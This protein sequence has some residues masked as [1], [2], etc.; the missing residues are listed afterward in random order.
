[1]DHKSSRGLYYCNYYS[2]DLI[3]IFSDSV[4]PNMISL[5]RNTD[6]SLMYIKHSH[7]YIRVSEP[8]IVKSFSKLQTQL[9]S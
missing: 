9:T 3:R 7:V 5:N 6:A 8:H 1:M 2:F 4:K